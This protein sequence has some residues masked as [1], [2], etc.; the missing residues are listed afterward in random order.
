MAENA[1]I[2][3]TISQERH[4]QLKEWADEMG[5]QF[6]QYIAMVSW[7]GAM[8]LRRTLHPELFVSQEVLAAALAQS[9]TQ[10]MKTPE[11]Q[12][13]M[14]QAGM[15]MA[16]Y[17]VENLPPEAFDTDEIKRMAGEDDEEEVVGLLRE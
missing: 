12:E 10:N 7:L 13:M 6:S 15:A 1:R 5:V 16:K 2:W 9:F 11:M 4:D 3:A 17:M 14:K 8:Q